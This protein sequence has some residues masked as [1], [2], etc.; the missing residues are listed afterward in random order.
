MERVLEDLMAA[1]EPKIEEAKAKAEQAQDEMAAEA[2]QAMDEIADQVEEKA[3]SAFIQQGPDM[4]AF[5][6]DAEIP[7]E[8][9]S[10]EEIIANLEASQDEAKAMMEEA[11][12]KMKAF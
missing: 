9:P 6:L 3:E 7:D 1:L 4:P 10:E 12:A 2:E 5:D 8:L 11:Q